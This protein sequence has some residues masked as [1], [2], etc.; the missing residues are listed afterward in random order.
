MCLLTSSHST[1]SMSCICVSV[2]V[3]LTLMYLCNSTKYRLPVKSAVDTLHVTSF[4]Y[5]LLNFVVF[6][7]I[8]LLAVYISASDGQIPIAIN[9]GI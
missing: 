6:Y 9:V 3:V 5:C 8:C 7:S 4:V 1:F 2:I